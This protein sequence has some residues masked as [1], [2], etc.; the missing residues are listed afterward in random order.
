[1]TSSP[2]EKNIVHRID[3]EVSELIKS[4]SEEIPRLIRENKPITA[5]Q[6][7]G[8]LDYSIQERWEQLTAIYKMVFENIDL[9]KHFDSSAVEVINKKTTSEGGLFRKKLILHKTFGMYDSKLPDDVTRATLNAK[10]KVILGKNIDYDK[11]VDFSN[12]RKII[13]VEIQFLIYIL[14]DIVETNWPPDQTQDNTSEERPNRH[15]SKEVKIAVWRRDQG[16]CCECGSKEKIEFDHIIPVSK[17]GSNTERNIQ[18]LCERCNRQKS[19][20]I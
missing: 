6:T 3:E 4:Y 17:G 11:I 15:I 1:M 16:K 12:L 18:L 9:L 7:L 19:A 10:S 5:I 8:F 2:I 20:K 13:F 14:K